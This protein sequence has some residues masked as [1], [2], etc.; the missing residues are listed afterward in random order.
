[1]QITILDG[2]TLNPGDNP[3]TQLEK[4]GNITVYDRTPLDAIIE[5][6]ADADI[7]VTNKV[8]LTAATLK[9]LP[10]LRYIAVTATG[11]DQVDIKA[12]A[13]LGIGVS[14][15]PNYGTNSVVQH[16]FALLFVLCRA[17]QR[18]DAS[19]KIGNWTGNKD[20]CFWE[21]TQVELTDKVMG[22][23]GYG[24]LG[25]H[26]AKIALAF[27][28]K[29]VAYTP[30]PTKDHDKSIQFVDLDTLFTTADVVSLH[31]PLNDSTRG[32]V[33][34]ERLATMK[35]GAYLLNTSRGPL[36]DEQAV[37]DALN[38]NHLG[39]LG[40]DV[41]SVEPIQ[42]ENPL[43]NAKN[44]IITPHLAWASLTARQTLMRITGENVAAFLAGTPNNLV[45]AK[46]MQ[47]K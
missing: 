4:L 26:V 25:S 8:P 19:V 13:E 29:V 41:V 33:N 28:M 2:Y 9:Q 23:V 18:H 34:A 38:N 24:N 37:A 5:R 39:G 12:A 14:N 10:K 16:V 31:C 40:V 17:V 42:P 44:C 3:W 20:W 15:V 35:R 1:M 46:Y 43:L 22:I 7:I 30:R 36:L 11:F 45:N 27:G 21:T 32:L 47:G 6:A